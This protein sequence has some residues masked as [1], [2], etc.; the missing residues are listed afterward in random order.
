MGQVAFEKD[1]NSFLLSEITEKDD[2]KCM[3]SFI[4]LM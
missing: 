1:I 2:F 3:K 4:S